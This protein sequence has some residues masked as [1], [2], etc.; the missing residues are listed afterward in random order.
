MPEIG[1]KIDATHCQEFNGNNIPISILKT[2]EMQKLTEIQKNLL[3]KTKIDQTE[4]YNLSL[5]QYLNI[6]QNGLLN[7]YRKQ[8]KDKED[9]QKI[10]LI[11]KNLKK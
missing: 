3:T 10:D 8:K 5:G 9:N 4:F 2:S 7:R 11:K 6:Y 1:Y